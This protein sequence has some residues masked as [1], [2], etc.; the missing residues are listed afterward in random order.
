M[1][2]KQSIIYLL[3]VALPFILLGS[4][5]NNIFFLPV[6]LIILSLPFHH[7]RNNL[8][9][10]WQMLG[11]LLSKIIS[12]VILSFIYYIALTPL[13]LIKRFTSIDPLTLKRPVHSNF[14][15]VSQSL[16]RDDFENLW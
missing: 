12:P 15:E 3:Q 2:K 11:V 9:K 5:K 10:Y 13:A 6:A 16:Q 1:S 14:K 7:A 8:I 4:L